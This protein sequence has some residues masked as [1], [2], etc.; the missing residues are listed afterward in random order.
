MLCSRCGHQNPDDARFCGE[1]GEPQRREEGREPAPYRPFEAGGETGGE[2]PPE[3]AARPASDIPERD[4]GQL[5]GET[6]SVYGKA[7]IPLFIIAL[8]PQIPTVLGFMLGQSPGEAGDLTGATNPQFNAGTDVFL[9]ILAFLLSIPSTAAAVFCVGQALTGRKVDVVTGYSRAFGVI[10]P[11]AAVT[12]IVSLALALSALL[13][14]IIIGIPLFFYLLVIWFFAMPAVVFEGMGGI[15]ALGRSR[16]LTRGSRWRLFGIGVVFTLLMMAIG[17]V[18]GGVSFVLVF[19]SPTLLAIGLVV[20]AALAIP[21]YYVGSVLVYVD[22]RV[23]KEGYTLQA[24]SDD[25][26]RRP[27]QA[28]Q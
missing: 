6:L 18:G 24:L 1:C 23:R 11:A 15:D 21:I 19:I 25:V 17:I 20:T 26:A 16:Q 8:I 13:M 3:G 12:I 14:L 7:F 28:R 2:S 22:L 5:I 10:L 4:L 9:P 27:E